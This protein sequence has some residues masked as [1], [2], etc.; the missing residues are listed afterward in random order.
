[1]LPMLEE[2]GA[3]IYYPFAEKSNII[4]IVFVIDTFYH[5]KA[6]KNKQ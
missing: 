1:M 2:I 6:V 5:D 3:I 4:M